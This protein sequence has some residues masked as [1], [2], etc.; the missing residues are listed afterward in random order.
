MRG[1]RFRDRTQAG[2]FLAAQLTPRFTHRADVL[3]LAL[4]RGGVPVGAAI[5]RALRAPLDVIVV[6]KL[7]APGQPEWAIG[8]IASGG[9]RV[10]NAQAVRALRLEAAEIDAI[11]AR[12]T[13][14]LERR[15]RTYRD[16]R[17]AAEVRGKTLVLVD[18]GLATGTTMRAAV[19]ALREREPAE[20]VVA[21]PV[22][23]AE[24][25]RELRD[26]ADAVFC[27][28]TPMPFFSVGEWY[29][30]FS[31]T[32]DDEVRTLLR[33]AAASHL[34]PERDSREG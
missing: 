17:A 26:L 9:V 24:T 27:A 25:C 6:R 7:G 2:E 16:G 8:A 20:V 32:T 33:R 4:P 14:E 11:A 31:Q 21:V 18:D 19:R 22:G 12:E 23:A 5:A 28:Q 15:E 3:V 10:L 13:V 1:F 34:P 30:D 29:E